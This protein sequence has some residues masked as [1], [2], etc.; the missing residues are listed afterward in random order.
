M[1]GIVVDCAKIQWP[2]GRNYLVV[3]EKNRRVVVFRLPEMTEVWEKEVEWEVSRVAW[4]K[5]PVGIVVGT[6]C[7][8]II[9][10]AGEVPQPC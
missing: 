8:K 6:A 1:P 5:K 10:F 3:G 9:R 2:D 4:T 7:G